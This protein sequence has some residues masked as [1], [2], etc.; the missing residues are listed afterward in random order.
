VAQEARA[1]DLG[2]R[3]DWYEKEHV[4]AR[5]WHP[6]ATVRCEPASRHQH[7]DVRVPLESASPGVQHRERADLRA[8]VAWVLGSRMGAEPSDGLQSLASESKAARN[9]TGKRVVW[10]ERTRRRS[11]AGSVKTT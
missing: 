2:E 11:S 4:A 3:L 1:E 9:S 5:Y 7:V 8:E 10:C 6:S